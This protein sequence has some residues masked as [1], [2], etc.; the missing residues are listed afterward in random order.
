MDN[1]AA[2]LEELCRK[3]WPPIYAFVRRRG[4]K[5]HE[6]EDLTQAFFA[7]LLEHEGIKK[8]EQAKGKFRTFLLASLTNFLNNEWDKRQTLKRGGQ[9]RI[10]SLDEA[11][12]EENYRNE[13]ADLLTPERIFERRW[14]QTLVDRTMIQLKDE[15]DAREKGR[16]FAVL[17]PGLTGETPA[18][19]CAEWAAALGMEEGAVRVALHR[20]RRRFGELLREEIAR[21]V[22]SQADIEEEIRQLFA[23]ITG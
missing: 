17:E 7:H 3:Y 2:A 23:A 13:P 6:A 22:A 16:L 21:T 8:A 5:P 12:A 4:S 10:I 1:A 15:Y 18:G 14:A 11:V 19:L 20:M 9:R